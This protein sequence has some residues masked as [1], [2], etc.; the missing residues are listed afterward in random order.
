MLAPL[1]FFFIIL[2]FIGFLVIIFLPKEE[3]TPKIYHSGTY[4][5]IRVSPREKLKKERPSKDEMLDFVR[6]IGKDESLVDEYFNIL[7]E[8][9]KEIEEG[10]KSGVVFFVYEKDNCSC[11]T[12]KNI[13][14]YYLRRR[15]IVENTS[16][17]PPFHLGCKCKIKGTFDATLIETKERIKFVNSKWEDIYEE[18]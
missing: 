2:F 1:I 11:E 4:S 15:D 3:E 16:L 7:E 18:S 9:I 17:I 12:C 14:N 6:K 5:I 8:N 13:D 10:D